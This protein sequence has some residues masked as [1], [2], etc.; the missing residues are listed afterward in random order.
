MLSRRDKIFGLAAVQLPR[1]GLSCSRTNSA[2][3]VKNDS[4][5]RRCGHRLNSN[6][7]SRAILGREA[8][9]S[10]IHAI[11]RCGT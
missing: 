9:A 6:R 2:N 4:L 1:Y 8:G 5:S 3:T 10:V 7:S 11:T